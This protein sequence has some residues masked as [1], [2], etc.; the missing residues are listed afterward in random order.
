MNAPEF[1]QVVKDLCRAQAALT[2]AARFVHLPLGK[3]GVS[4]RRCQVTRFPP[5]PLPASSSARRE[6]ARCSAARC[7]CRVVLGARQGLEMPPLAAVGGLVAP[8]SLQAPS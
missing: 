5:V 6:L 8:G 1:S 7:S 4:D 2:A 3:A